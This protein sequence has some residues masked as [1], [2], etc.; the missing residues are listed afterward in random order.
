MIPYN[1]LDGYKSI[2]CLN[3]ELPNKSFFA[4]DL[5]IIAADGAANQLVGM[6]I[7]PD[8]IIGDL[9]SIVIQDHPHSMIISKPEQS[10]SDFQKALEYVELNNLLPTLVTGVG[11]G[12]IDHI[13][14]NINVI[15]KNDCTFYAHPILGY[16]LKAPIKFD[17]KLNKATKISLFAMAKA[18]VTTTGLKW[19]LKE[20][21]L[22]FPGVNSALNRVASEDVT[23]EVLE[24]NLLVLIYTKDIADKGNE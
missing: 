21:V 1:F 3:G 24:G 14:N 13:L 9:D 8:V 7:T 2:L 17:I 22:E 23:I 11:G 15:L 10:R 16:V 18:K 19:D 6:G 12:F 20:D 5:P 4:N